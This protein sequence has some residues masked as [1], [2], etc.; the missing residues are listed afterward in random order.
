M[1]LLDTY[2]ALGTFLEHW[3]GLPREGL[4]PPLGAYLD[5]PPVAQQPYVAISDL[6]ST[7]EANIRLMG[8]A[9]AQA[10][11]ERT[12]TDIVDSYGKEIAR[13]VRKLAWSAVLH[14]AGYLAW[15][16]FARTQ[17]VPYTVQT[18]TLPLIGQSVPHC[19]VTYFGL[20]SRDYRDNDPKWLEQ[21]VGCEL[22][23]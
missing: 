22:Q 6:V 9:L 16:R 2:P 1:G 12:G 10:V 23:G 14:P 4:V 11:G 19:V 15:R 7:D 17:G 3:R 21:S 8:T 20:D 5:N 13:Y 18:I